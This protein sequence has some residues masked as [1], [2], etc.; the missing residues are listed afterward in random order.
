MGKNSLKSKRYIQKA[1]VFAIALLAFLICFF[2]NDDGAG[3][4]SSAER[5]ETSL[6]Q[7]KSE[8]FERENGFLVIFDGE[9]EKAASRLAAEAKKSIKIATYTFAKSAFTRLLELRAK[10][11]L[12][13]RVVAGKN[14]DNSAPLFEFYV[15]SM[16]SGIYHPKFMVFDSK[17]VLILSANISSDSGARNN[18]VLFFDVPEAAAILEAEIDAQF[19]GKNERRCDV[20]CESEIGTIYFNPGRGC[21]AVRDEL[22]GATER[23]YGGIYTMT[24]KNP[25][26]TG[27]KR[28]AKRGVPVSIVVDNWRGRE[29]DAVNSRAYNFLRSIGIDL[30]FD[31]PGEADEQLFHHKSVVIDGKTT[32]LGSMNWT[33]SGCYK[34]R[35][36]VVINRD[37]GIAEGFEKYFKNFAVR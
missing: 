10:E 5:P 24:L 1:E 36:L 18:A 3:E 28:A 31:E 22:S 37:A 21:A 2:M 34:N 12:K 32:V 17:D 30:I 7:E 15:L 13:V 6:H 29:G 26:V 35:E 9:I 19:E 23:I 25:M 16:K 4:P 20:G 8:P 33:A 27:L 11:N 14:K